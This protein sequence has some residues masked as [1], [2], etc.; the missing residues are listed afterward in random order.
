MEFEFLGLS[1]QETEELAKEMLTSK[2]PLIAKS[3]LRVIPNREY[4]LFEFEDGLSFY[5][6]KEGETPSET[7]RSY[8]NDPVM[9]NYL[10][11]TY[12]ID[13]DPTVPYKVLDQ[14][15]EK[16]G[17]RARD[18]MDWRVTSWDGR[19]VLMILIPQEVVTEMMKEHGGML[20]T[21]I[22]GPA[23]ALREIPTMKPLI[24]ESVGEEEHIRR[25]FAT[26]YGKEQYWGAYQFHMNLLNE[27]V[28]SKAA[29]ISMGPIGSWSP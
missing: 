10:P 25:V 1:R 2:A 7:F 3:K 13:E 22:R 8:L 18:R 24:A 23:K 17:K 19:T 5:R 4:L 15:Q 14:F 11:A 27:V 26:N 6:T 21:F 28:Q 29:G 16:Y 20:A 9:P 12:E